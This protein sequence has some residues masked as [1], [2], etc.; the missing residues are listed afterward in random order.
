MN[1]LDLIRHEYLDSFERA[2]Q[3]YPLI[4]ARTYLRF[5]FLYDVHQW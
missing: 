5:H 3:G 1:R 4:A 2:E